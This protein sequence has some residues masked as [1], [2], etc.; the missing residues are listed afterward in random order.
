P[1]PPRPRVQGG[2]D[3]HHAVR[4]GD[5]ERPGPVPPGHGRDRPGPGAWAT[6]SAPAAGHGGPAP[7]VSGLHASGGG[8]PPGR[9]RLDLA[10]LAW[11]GL[12]LVRIL[13]V[14]AGSS[15]LKLRVL[16]D[17]DQVVGTKDLPAPRDQTDAA[18]VAGAIEEFGP[19]DA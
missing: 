14:N 11:G 15:S 18:A 19:V 13:V 12:A 8:G 3:H 9:A 1:E 17:A 2:G 7:G 16:D 4:H 10:P 6:G 5:A